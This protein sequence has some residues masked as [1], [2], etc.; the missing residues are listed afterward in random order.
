[1]LLILIRVVLYFRV[2]PLPNLEA[3]ARDLGTRLEGTRD[4]R[5]T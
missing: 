4:I 3:E 5:G 1:M 2:T